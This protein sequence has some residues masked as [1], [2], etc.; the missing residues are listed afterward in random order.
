MR[1]KEKEEEEEDEKEEQE[2]ETSKQV[3]SNKDA[4]FRCKFLFNIFFIL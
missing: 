2:E 4:A 3:L 1:H